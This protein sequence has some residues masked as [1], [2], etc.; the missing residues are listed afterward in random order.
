[1]TT[2]CF[3]DDLSPYYKLIYLD[4]EASI[5]RQASALNGVICEFFVQD[6]LS[7]WDVACGIGTQSIGLAALG[8][9][10]TASDLS[11]SEIE[12]AKSETAHRGLKIDYFVSDMRFLDCSREPVDLL[13]ACDNAIPHLLNNT[14]IL[15]TFK[16]FYK[17]IKKGGGCIISVRD[18]AMMDR[19]E[20]QKMV[21]R[22]L[23]KTDTGQIVMFDVWALD[24]DIYEITT[25]IIEDTGKQQAITQ[26]VRG[27]KYYCVEIPTL[28]KLFEDAGFSQVLTVR[29][30]FFQPLIL[31]IKN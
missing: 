20:R 19:T 27:G 31:A 8:Y 30:R 13:I 15:E 9:Q 1:M 28:V 17:V 3:Y 4:W 14:E 23:H 7:I 5:Q 12:I 26:V 16:G 2:E 18:Y 11:S 10:V 22:T 29:D 21:P 25:Y 24:G 6:G